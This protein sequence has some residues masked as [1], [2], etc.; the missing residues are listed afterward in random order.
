LFRSNIRKSLAR[1]KII[2]HSSRKLNIVNLVAQKIDSKRET[3]IHV[4]MLFETLLR[5]TR[6]L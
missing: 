2:V 4:S 5:V 6:R 3:F 1:N